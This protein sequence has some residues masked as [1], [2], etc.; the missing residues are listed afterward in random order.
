[1]SGAGI[2]PTADAPPSISGETQVGVVLTASPGSWSGSQP[3]DYSYTW[4]R[5]DALGGACSTIPGSSAQ[6]LQLTTDDLARTVRVGVTASNVAGWSVATSLQTAPV[7]A[8][9]PGAAP[10]FVGDFETGLLS[11]WEHAWPDASCSQVTTASGQGA[12]AARLSVGPSY[13]RTR[14]D[15]NSEKCELWLESH[16]DSGHSLNGKAFG[17]SG[18]ETWDRH[19][20]Y[21]PTN[22]V[23]SP[24]EWNWFLQWHNDSGYYDFTIP[25]GWEEVNLA[26]GIYHYSGQPDRWFLRT[27]GGKSSAPG[28][29]S[30]KFEAL[31]PAVQLGRWI[32]FVQHVVWSPDPSQGLVESWVN[33]QLIASRHTPTL[34]VRPDGSV[35]YVNYQLG[36]YRYNP[37]SLGLP[38]ASILVDAAKVGPTRDSVK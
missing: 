37:P 7:T 4:Q 10:Y 22:F 28:H 3:I 17:Y 21:L 12:H 33:G 20:I 19:L 9:P 25:G 15:A 14:G 2:V 6:T 18:S 27:Y 36:Y 24:G 38:N 29:G 30:T 26:I 1:M 5:C 8:A 16:Q 23:A 11:P 35:S 34:Y 13:P 31:G 32:E